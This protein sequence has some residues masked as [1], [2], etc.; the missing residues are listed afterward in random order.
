MFY[1]CYYQCFYC[2]QIQHLLKLNKAFNL[3]GT[4]KNNSNTT[5]VK[6]KFE[7]GSTRIK[8]VLIK[9]QIQH[10]LKLNIADV[11]CLFVVV[12]IFKYNIC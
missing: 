5:F 7:F 1:F 6:V 11:S 12:S 2:I 10:L 3:D 9:I 8:A 4:I